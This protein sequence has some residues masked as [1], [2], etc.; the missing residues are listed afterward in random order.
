MALVWNVLGA[1]ESPVEDCL[2][3]RVEPREKRE[4]EERNPNLQKNKLLCRKR[5]IILV[6][7]VP[8]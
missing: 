2:S 1:A 5:K 8:L 3:R 4:R 6:Y 7:G